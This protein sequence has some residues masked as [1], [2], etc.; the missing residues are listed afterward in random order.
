MMIETTPAQ[1]PE[2]DKLKVFRTAG[3]IGD[4]ML[5]NGAETYRV[6]DT[7]RRVLRT[8]GVND[9]EAVAT[10]TGLTIS[11]EDPSSAPMTSVRRVDTRISH[12]GKIEVA[13]EIS[14]EYVSRR[15]TI[16]EAY[17]RL[18]ELDKNPLRYHWKIVI[19]VCSLTC[20]CFCLLFGGTMRDF[21]ATLLAG[22]LYGCFTHLTDW[23][24]VNSFLKTMLASFLIGLFTL[25]FCY[26][27]PLGEHPDLVIAGCIMPLV[28]G[29]S[30]MNGI[31]DTL[32]GDY[33][34]GL[35]R[36]I[37]AFLTA[38]LIAGGAGLLMQGLSGSLSYQ[39]VTENVVP[40]LLDS[41]KGLL[42]PYYAVQ[43]AAA[44][45]SALT[46][47]VIMKATPKHLLYCGICGAAVWILYLALPYLGMSKL[48]AVFLATFLIC[49]LA[50]WFARIRKAPTTIFFTAITINLVPGYGMYKFMFYL[51]GREYENALVCGMDTLEIAALIAAALATHLS[52]RKILPFFRRNG[53]K[54]STQI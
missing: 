5:K 39:A 15:I 16:D 3:L 13:N 41:S 1:Q 23:I 10:L 21:A 48:A 29:L 52:I 47:C 17:E 25:L 53:K 42:Q 27:I 8:A 30:I 32:Y 38:L 34:S 51:I 6:E 37:E 22:L 31:Q 28:P 33:L 20:G 44:F 7:V 9:A 43:T 11:M 40:W 24:P 54:S 4:I 36:L 18:K 2:E 49:P 12:L 14:R 45:L 46:F 26:G 35:A 19:P 50:S